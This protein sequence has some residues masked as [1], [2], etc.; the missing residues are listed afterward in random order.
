IQR[1]SRFRKA[2]RGRDQ[3]TELQ[4]AL[5]QCRGRLKGCSADLEHIMAKQS[6]AIQDGTRLGKDTHIQEDIHWDAAMG[7][8][9]VDDAMYAL[10]SISSEQSIA[11]AY[12]L[13]ESATKKLAKEG[14]A[15]RMPSLKFGKKKERNIYGYKT[16]EVN[17]EE[18][19]E[20]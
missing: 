20:I 7:Y 4:M 9:L 8:L 10:E 6:R 5:G 19:N 16:V 12:E 11:Y 15:I 1:D 18:K 13:L 14:S 3:S 2:A 17:L